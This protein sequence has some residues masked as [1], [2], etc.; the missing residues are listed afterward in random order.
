MD[1]A[2]GEG[3]DQAAAVR[4]LPAT[5]LQWPGL[6]RV[7]GPREKDSNSCCGQRFL[8]HDQ[9]DNRSALR[10]EMQDTK[11]PIGLLAYLDDNVVGWTRV[12]SRSML[13]GVTENLALAR[14]LDNDPNAW[15]VSCFVVRREHREK[16]IGA[17]C[18]TPVSRRPRST[19]P[20]CSTATPWTPALS[21][22]LRRHPPSS[23]ELSPCFDGPGS[24][25]SGAP[26]QPD[27]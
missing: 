19:A 23:P 15:W 26:T 21:P 1:V 13:Q 16:G 3:S 2:A 12:V 9:P 22:A 5:A 27:R 25:R 14:I 24:P 8:G 17:A 6:R 18:S 20:R 4:I 10:R 11:V 7:F